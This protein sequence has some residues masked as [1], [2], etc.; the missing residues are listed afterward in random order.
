MVELTPV[1]PMPYYSWDY[2]FIVLVGFVLAERN[3]GLYPA[4]VFAAIALFPEPV[5]PLSVSAFL[6]YRLRQ[7]YIINYNLLV[8]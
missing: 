6:L 8:Y 1:Y 7:C 4:S 2:C 5:L 3:F